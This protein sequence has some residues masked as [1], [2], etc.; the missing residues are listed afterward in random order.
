[1]T[2]PHNKNA[3]ATTS[4]Q[5]AKGLGAYGKELKR[6]IAAALQRKETSLQQLKHHT[7]RLLKTDFD[8]RAFADTCAQAIAYGLFVAR[9]RWQKRGRDRC[10]SRREACDRMPKTSLFLHELFQ[11]IVAP[12]TPALTSESVDGAIAKIVALLDRTDVETMFESARSPRPWQDPILHFY[13]DFLAAYDRTS[14][15]QHGVYY[16][17]EPVVSFMV[18]SVDEILKERFDFP[19]GLADSTKDPKTNGDRVAI[20]DPA[21]GT[22]TFLNGV[23]RQMY[24]NLESIGAADRWD[25]YVR[26]N[27]LD[28]VIGFELL[29]T[30]Y[31]IAHL[32]L[33]LT[34]ETL[35]G[36]SPLDNSQRDKNLRIDL[37]NVL[38][39]AIQNRLPHLPVTVVL[40]NPPYSGNSRN[41]GS[42]ID[43]L[44]RD[45]YQ[46]NGVAL[47]ER[48]PKYLQDDYV[49][50]IRLGQ[51]CVERSRGGILA[52]VTNRG[53]L[54]NSTFRGMRRSLM[55]TFD[56]LYVLDLHGSS[57][58]P[59]PAPDGAKDENIFDVRAGIAIAFFVRYPE[60]DRANRSKIYYA[61]LWGPREILQTKNDRD[62][63]LIGG[64][65]HWLWHNSFTTTN[66]QPLQPVAP[67]DYFVPVASNGRSQYE[68]FWKITDIFSAYSMGI[69]TARDRFVV[70]W[71]KEEV[72]EVLQDFVALSPEAARAKYDLGEDSSSWKVENAQRDARSSGLQPRNVRA[73]AYRPFDT[74]FAYYTG[75]SGG[76]MERP[77]P[78]ATRHLLAGENLAFCFVRRSREGLASNFFIADSVVD[79]TILSSADNAYF[80]PLYIYT[81][82]RQNMQKN[83]QQKQEFLFAPACDRASNFTADFLQ[84]VRD[85]LGY[86]PASEALFSYLYAICHSPTYRWRYADAIALDFPRLPLPAC[87]RTFSAL[88][89]FGKELIELHLLRSPRLETWEIDFPAP[90]SNAID[91]V[92]YDGERQRIYIN[93]RQYFAGVAPETWQFQ[94]GGYRVLEK[95][96]KTRMKVKRKLLFAD[97]WHYRKIAAA[98]V[99]T[100]QLTREIDRVAS[101]LLE[102]RSP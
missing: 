2:D 95:W 58:P 36:R 5:L 52:F 22:G 9:M 6:A 87:D 62:R 96:L 68:D 72:L 94:I 80:A 20:L 24:Q 25:R 41:Q 23:I 17:P 74:R 90:G 11:A 81:N 64:K 92:G 102:A 93:D 70:R 91:R 49:K 34:L 85:R 48:N 33:G 69:C 67:D 18:R 8:D 45:Y 78:E 26:E 55:A 79:K 98:A 66:W 83:T 75:N 14:R 89:R 30:P 60:R 1:M 42:W 71:Q 40:G 32:K 16:T 28:R 44:V 10:F 97:T 101:V 57:R 29:A 61:D 12:R 50:F 56:E 15:K 77:R 35:G 46:V 54:K 51:W 31:A 43:R 65:Y 99:A 86:L 59:E 37:A 13:E 3:I 84:A 63:E 88:S 39:E 7:Q 73:V 21:T 4:Q 47:N 27:L 53:Y 38:D 19:L 76:L 100:Q 82:R